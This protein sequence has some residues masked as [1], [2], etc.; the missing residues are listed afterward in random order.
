MKQVLVACKSLV[1]IGISES[2][3]IA[4]TKDIRVSAVNF[5][6]KVTAAPNVDGVA[7]NRAINSVSATLVAEAA[8]RSVANAVEDAASC[9]C[10]RATHVPL[11][12]IATIGKIDLK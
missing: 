7:I 6:E 5:G 3:P 12:T 1:S 11:R 10:K 2:N 8:E 4:S 9:S